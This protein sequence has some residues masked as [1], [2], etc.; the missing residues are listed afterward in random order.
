VDRRALAAQ[1]VRAF[2]SFEAE[3]GLKFDKIY[4]IYSQRFHREDLEGEP[5]DP[6]VLPTAYL[7]DPKPG[8]AFVYVCTIQRMMINLFGR[9]VIAALG[10][11]VIDEDVE[12]LPIPIHA[13][14]V[15]IA[16]ECHRGYTSTE[17]SAWRNTL[18]HFDA[19]KIGL[20]ATPAA[21]TTAYFKDVVFRYEYERAV[22]EGYL[23]DYDVVAVN[24]NVRIK[25]IFL[26][27]GEQVG[28]VNPDSGAEQL[29]FLE[30]ER[31]FPTE[32][33]EEKVTSPD[34][35][36]KILEEIKRYALEHEQRTG[37]FP[38]TLIFAVGRREREP[39]RRLPARAPHVRGVRSTLAEGVAG[40][41]SARPTIE[42]PPEVRRVENAAGATRLAELEA[43]RRRSRRVRGRVEAR[44]GQRSA[45]DR[46]H[47]AR[48]SPSQARSCRR[49]PADDRSRH[50]RRR[51]ALLS[52]RRGVSATRSRDKRDNSDRRDPGHVHPIRRGECG[53]TTAPAAPSCP[54]LTSR[55]RRCQRCVAREFR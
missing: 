5:F 25:G 31:Q 47:R 35:N 33:V 39:G 32:E 26:K 7:T 55:S 36:R 50:A 49:A 24:S 45:R 54:D 23:V 9:Q 2:A 37:R 8:H 27:E 42:H 6:K 17:L 14:D 40:R 21:H 28:V 18:D 44:S 48:R 29:D 22:R 4:E 13:F 19:V 51:Q 12:Q 16:D 34:S 46:Q 11:E 30:D 52:R 15:V 20:T 10:D 43:A 38:K 53:A 41:A 3:P 1:A